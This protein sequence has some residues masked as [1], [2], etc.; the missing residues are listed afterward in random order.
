M[1]WQARYGAVGKVRDRTG[2][3]GAE[4]I[5]WAR[6]GGYGRPGMERVG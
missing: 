6:T 3:A 4:W 2:G 5:G 1:E